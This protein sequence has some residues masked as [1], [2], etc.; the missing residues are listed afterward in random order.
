MRSIL[1]RLWRYKA[2]TIFMGLG[3]M[4]AVLATVLLLTITGSVRAKFEAFIENAYPANGVVLMAGGGPMSGS[5][6]GTKNLRVSDVETVVSSVGVTEWD[7][8]LFAGS[9]DVKRGANN[10]RVGVAG[11]SEKAESVRGRSVQE[12]EFFSSD[13]VSARGRVALIGSTTAEQLFPG[14]SAVGGQLFIDNIPF[15][16]KGVLE[17]VGVDVHGNDQDNAIWVPYTTLMEQMLKVNYVSGVTLLL[18]DRSRV[19]EVSEEVTRIMR[20]RH[21]IAAGQKDD[22][23]VANSA[24]MQQMLD[25][26]FNT[27][28]VFIPLIAATAFLISALVI[29]SIMQISIKGRIREIGLRKALGARSRDLQTQI[30]LEVLIVAVI[31]CLVGILLAQAGIMIAA[32]ILAEKMGVRQENPSAMVLVIAVGAALVTGLLGGVLPARRAAKLRPVEALK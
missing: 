2:K 5:T 32:P 3:I 6:A 9:R 26:S 15:Q 10:L 22:F 27:F 11:F 14:E 21:Q 16:V 30:V 13:D 25:R 19:G 31:A 29:L 24:S 12:G 28:N 20:E 8:A 23:A 7:P 18:E 4:I 17:A 1:S